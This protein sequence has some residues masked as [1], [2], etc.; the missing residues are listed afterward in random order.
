MIGSRKSRIG[1]C[2]SNFRSCN[3][4]IMKKGRRSSHRRVDVPEFKSDWRRLA[5]Y[6][7]M[8]WSVG[9]SRSHRLMVHLGVLQVYFCGGCDQLASSLLADAAEIKTNRCHSQMP[10]QGVHLAKAIPRHKTTC[11]KITLCSQL[12]A[13]GTWLLGLRSSIFLSWG[14]LAPEKAQ[15][16]KI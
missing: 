3:P 6:R 13:L 16:S 15:S 10:K 12:C 8:G 4:K 1:P 2:S 11:L 5:G 7:S 14:S 9:R